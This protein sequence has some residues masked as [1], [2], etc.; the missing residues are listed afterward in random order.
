MGWE[1]ARACL[2][3]ARPARAVLKKRSEAGQSSPTPGFVPSA[4]STKE[5]VHSGAFSVP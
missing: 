3:P 5:S 4:S 1:C 2:C